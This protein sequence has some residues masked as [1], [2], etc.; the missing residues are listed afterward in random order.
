MSSDERDAR[1]WR[2]QASEIA[3]ALRDLA[4]TIARRTETAKTGSGSE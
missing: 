1:S 4:S 2:E 3:D